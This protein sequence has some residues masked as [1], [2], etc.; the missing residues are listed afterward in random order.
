MGQLRA[1]KPGLLVCAA[2][3][4]FIFLYLRSSTPEAADTEPTY[5]AAVECGF[6]PD[7]LC[8]ALFEGKKA[9]PQIAKLCTNP[10]ISNIL[11]YVHKAGNCSGLSQGLRFITTPLSAEEGNFSLAYIITIHKE[12]AMFVQL[13]RAIYAPQN[14]YCIRVDGKVPWKYMTAVQTLAHCF[15]NIFVSSQTQKVAYTNHGRLQADISCMK[16]LVRSKLRWKHVINLCG[17]DFPIKT[18]REII[19]YLRSKWND[20]N[21]TP[22]VAVPVHPQSPQ[23]QG[24]TEPSP[25]GSIHAS[26]KEGFRQEPP[27]NLTV[28]SGSAYYLLTRKFVEFILTDSRAKD[29]LQWAKDIHSPEQYYWVTLNRLKDAPGAT[30]EAGWEGNVRAIKWRT[31]E[32]KA[33]DGCK[34]HYVQDTCVYGPGDLPWI[35]QSPC[36]FASKFEPSSEPLV[37]TCLERRHRLRVLAQA[38]VPIEPHWHFQQESHFNMKLHC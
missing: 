2:V 27:H 7:E 38:E 29:M 11:E 30:P 22:G 13:L 32:G 9:A 8:A 12:L 4:I 10:P 24:L 6:Y 3:C 17:Q 26:L 36:L 14:V 28:Y 31:E 1:T 20:K 21:L 35:I 23:G 19:Q 37:V 18:N 34:G 15:E 16:D 33:H 5:P 25:A